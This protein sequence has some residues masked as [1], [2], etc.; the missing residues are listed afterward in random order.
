MAISD[1]Q[2]ALGVF[3]VFYRRRFQS[4]LLQY[5]DYR[6]QSEQDD[7]FQTAVANNMQLAKFVRALGEMTVK[8][9]LFK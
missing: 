1:Q 7:V 5:G 8:K 4:E 6:D 3:R 9:E 2:A